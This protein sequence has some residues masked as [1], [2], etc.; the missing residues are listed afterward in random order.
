MS[1][2]K[3]HS[4]TPVAALIEAA[5]EQYEPDAVRAAFSPLYPEL[6]PFTRLS[7]ID[8]KTLKRQEFTAYAQARRALTDYRTSLTSTA[9]RLAR[10]LDASEEDIRELAMQFAKRDFPGIQKLRWAE[11]LLGRSIPGH[12]LDSQFARLGDARFWRRSIRTTLMRE[13]EHFFLR[14]KLVGVSGERY[15]SDAQ[16]MTRLAQL[17]RQRQW[18][19][20]TVLVPRYLSSAE[21]FKPL[22]LA[23]VAGDP[24][25]RFAKLYTF[26]KAM[27][28]LAQDAGLVSA[29]VTLTALPEWHPNPSHGD[30]SWNGANPREAH[31]HIAECWNAVQSELYKRGVGISGMRVVEPH[32]DGC[33]H[34][35]VWLIYRPEVE[36]DILAALLRH[37]PGK[38]KLRSPSRKGQ[39]PHGKDVIYETRADVLAGN[40][41]P[42]HTPKEGAQVEVSRIDPTISSGA[43]YAMKYLLKTVDGGESLVREVDLFGERSNAARTEDEIKAAEDKRRKH[44]QAVERVDGW[45]ALWGMNSAMLFGVARCLSAWDELRRL[46]TPPTNGRLFRLWVLARGS[47]K[48]GRIVAGSGQQGDAKAFLQA[49]GG[50]TA[51]RDPRDKTLLPKLRLGRLTE[52]GENAYGDTIQRPKGL[53]LIE[54][55]TAT[56]G[57]SRSKTEQTVVASVVTRNEQWLLVKADRISQAVEQATAAMAERLRQGTPAELGERAVRQFWNAFHDARTAMSTDDSA[58]AL[59]EP[60]PA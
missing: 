46:P 12:C 10:W 14:L 26:V 49:L 41:R 55:R 48:A 50:I 21:G 52:E 37:F 56:K 58:P 15:V 22:T 36:N 33:P 44:E 60:T 1:L 35:H 28:S 5:C 38:L 54:R 20:E 51:A 29:L 31:Q 25:K 16:V 4:K 42:L 57:A 34:W 9:G 39:R 47:E 27:E 19:E 30:N 32:Q 13:R 2:K 17:R 11:Q 7:D 43:S 23:S 59:P 24:R 8:T 53:Q 45:R 6:S 3:F 18:M 40:S